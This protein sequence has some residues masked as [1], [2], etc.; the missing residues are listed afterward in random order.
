MSLVPA[1]RFDLLPMKHYAFASVQFSR[2]CPFTCEFCAIIVTFGCR[3]RLR[4]SWQIL[5]E[6]ENLTALASEFVFIVDDNLNG[7]KKAIK[8]ILCD[9]KA[10]QKRRGYPLTFFT[11]ASLDLADDPE[12]PALFSEVNIVSGFVGIESPNE[13]AL[14]GPKKKQNVRGSSAWS[15]RST[16]SS[17][18]AWRSGA[19]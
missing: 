10:W 16:P 7:N 11:E 9:L 6:I 5:A 18:P 1:P 19:A 3:A 14:I 4:R 12:L 8:P 17:A 2:G 15:R 13:A